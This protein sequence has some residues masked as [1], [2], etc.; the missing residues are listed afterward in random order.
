MPIVKSELVKNEEIIRRMFLPEV[1]RVHNM[2]VGSINIMPT[3]NKGNIILHYYY[4]FAYIK[5]QGR[6][7]YAVVNCEPLTSMQDTNFQKLLLKATS[8]CNCVKV[9]DVN[10]LMGFVDFTDEWTQEKYAEWL[11]RKFFRA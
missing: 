3:G 6:Q 8:E 2:S 4:P 1:S 7:F 5:K 9:A 11:E 10:E